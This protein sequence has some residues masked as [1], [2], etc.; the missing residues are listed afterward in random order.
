[1]ARGV[2][3]DGVGHQLHS[4]IQYPPAQS[5]TDTVNLFHGLTTVAGKPLDQQ[6]TELDMSTYAGAAPTIYT[7][8]SQIPSDLFVQQGY[9]YR[10]FFQ[11]LKQLNSDPN[12]R[13][14][15]SVTFWGMADDDTWLTSSTKVDAPLLFDTGLQHKPAYTGIIDP[16]DLPGA[17]LQATI[18]A[19]AGSVLSGGAVSYTI[20]V[21]NNGHDDA[22]SVSLLDTI[23]SSASFQSIAAPAGWSCT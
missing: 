19:S 7:D 1:I 14:I 13:K 4:N 12:H 9:L 20:T 5:I 2:P 15:S 22:A 3:I 21:L 23:P 16:L 6:V 17:D 18:S 10:D 8:Y 11:A